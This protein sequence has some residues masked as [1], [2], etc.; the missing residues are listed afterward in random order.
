MR[1]DNYPSSSEVV[2]NLAQLKVGWTVVHEAGKFSV[3]RMEAPYFNGSEFWVVN[4]K[5]F[6]WEPA[7]NLEA[8]LEYLNS[9]EA[10]DYEGAD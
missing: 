3:V 5:G 6:L 4:E 1:N 2:R 8:A 9:D 7:A 10:R